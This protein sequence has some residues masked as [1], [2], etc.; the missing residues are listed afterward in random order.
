M[1]GRESPAIARRQLAAELRRLRHAAGRTLEDVAEVLGC[2]AAKIS[3]LETGIVR[4]QPEDASNLLDVY[5]VSADRRREF[6][7]LLHESHRREWWHS[8]V[9][10][11]PPAAGKFYSLE[12]AATGVQDYSHGLLPGLLQTEQYAR[13]LIGSGDEKSKVVDRRVELRMRRQELLT[14]DGAP[15]CT[16]LIG[17]S[18]LRTR[19][20][21]RQVMIGQFE[22][23]LDV[24]TRSNVTIRIVP[25]IVHPA[26]GVS[27]IILHFTPAE[28][29]SVTFIEAL[30]RNIFVE[31]LR[32]VRVYAET[33]KAVESISLSVE[34]SRRLLGGPAR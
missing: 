33:F 31:E 2:T 15:V 23:L 28:H 32:E 7:A 17:E 26:T 12:A 9:D 18:A 11:V 29:P 21:S 19:V 14:T 16:F 4:V 6:L 8:Y 22:R 10:V 20:G 3:R 5:D 13:A 34:D 30:T 1:V 25:S 24:G 27:F